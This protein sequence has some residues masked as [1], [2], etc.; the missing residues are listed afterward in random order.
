MYNPKLAKEQKA[1]LP[2][3]ALVCINQ[4]GI[5]EEGIT[6]EQ[7]LDLL[8]GK[9]DNVTGKVKCF[10]KCLLE[11]EGFF[12]NGQV[13]PDVVEQKLV[14]FGEDKVKSV[15]AKC[16]SLKGSDDCDT[17]FQLYKCY[18]ESYLG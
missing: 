18:Y 4:E 2:D 12:V 7:G 9:F 13:K 5:T 14:P 17:A 15:Q 3:Y 16:D 11:K 6:E 10:A 1:N 8:E